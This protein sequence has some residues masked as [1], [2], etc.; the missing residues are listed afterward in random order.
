MVHISAEK[1]K[2]ATTMASRMPIE[3]SIAGRT[4]TNTGL[5]AAVVRETPKIMAK[6]LGERPADGELRI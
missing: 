5:P 4:E 3:W 1:E 2:I 6:A